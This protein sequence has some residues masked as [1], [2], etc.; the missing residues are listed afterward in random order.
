ATDRQ[1]RFGHEYVLS[2]NGEHKKNK[3]DERISG[4]PYVFSSRSKDS[5]AKIS[6]ID[7][8]CGVQKTQEN[9]Q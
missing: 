1:C 2:A 9:K 6:P 4:H 5:H 3:L 8:R 7:V